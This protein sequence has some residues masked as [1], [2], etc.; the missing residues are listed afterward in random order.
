MAKTKL[1]FGS[2]SNGLY[3]MTHPRTTPASTPIGD[4]IRFVDRQMNSAPGKAAMDLAQKIP[5]PAG[6]N[7]PP[8]P[9]TCAPSRVSTARTV[10]SAFKFNFLPPAERL[11]CNLTHSLHMPGAIAS[12]IQGVDD[13]AHHRWMDAAKDGLSVITHLL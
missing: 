3:V 12:G 10:P 11:S 9:A 6:E 1:S 8:P 2:N 7:P 5:G 4:A 13:L